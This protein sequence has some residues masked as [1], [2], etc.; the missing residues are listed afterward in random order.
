MENGW[1]SLNGGSIRIN[2]LPTNVKKQSS[3][4]EL[5]IR[6]GEYEVTLY[7]DGVL[8]NYYVYDVVV[9]ND[10]YDAGDSVDVVGILTDAYGNPIIG[11]TLVFDINSNWLYG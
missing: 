11:K 10:V 3:I 5:H 8:S 2:Y 6:S 4:A 9:G 7:L 1:D